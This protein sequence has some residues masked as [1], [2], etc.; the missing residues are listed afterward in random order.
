MGRGVVTVY[1]DSNVSKAIAAMDAKNIGSVVVLDNLGPCGVFT[2]RD[3]LKRVLGK[4]RDP[5]TTVVTEVLSSAFP[6]LEASATVEEA[7]KTMIE[8]KS[9][10]MIFEGPD[11]VGMVTPTDLVRAFRRLDWDFSLGGVVSKKVFTVLPETPVDVVVRLMGEEGIGSVIVTDEASE[12]IF[13]ER[14]LLRRVLGARRR[15]DTSVEE[16]ASSP[17]I[18]G[19]PEVGGREAAEIMA[20]NG[21]KRLPLASEGRLA[22][23]VTARDVVEAYASATKKS[24]AHPVEWAQWN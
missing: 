19:R 11:L 6:S 16:V 15:L 10:L 8:R 4:G 13:T 9:R 14:D 17:L 22:G 20:S 2:E 23:I 18:T 1:Q 5:E 7:A 3:L 24:A 12:G 21:I